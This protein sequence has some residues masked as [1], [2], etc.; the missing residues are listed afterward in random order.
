V[1]D[2]VVVH[3]DVVRP[4]RQVACE[5][6]LADAN[7]ARAEVGQ[8]AVAIRQFWQPRRNQAA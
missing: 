3:R 1:V 5:S 7:A 4:F 6:A 2:D 8:V